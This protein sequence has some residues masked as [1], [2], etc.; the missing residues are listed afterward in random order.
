MKV[1]WIIIGLV[2][3]YVIKDPSA[4]ALTATHLGNRLGDAGTS[5]GTFMSRLGA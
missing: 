2:A 3:I 4:A 5:L 1:R